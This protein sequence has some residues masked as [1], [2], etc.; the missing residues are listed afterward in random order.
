MNQDDMPK[1]TRETCLMIAI[2]PVDWQ[3]FIDG[4]DLLVFFRL[5]IGPL[6]VAWER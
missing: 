3:L 5:Q 6:Y 1:I 4:P 2:Y